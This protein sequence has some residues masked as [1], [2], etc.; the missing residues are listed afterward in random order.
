MVNYGAS[1]QLNDRMT[2]ILDNIL[3]AM[4]MTVS[5][6]Y[7]M[8]NAV[9]SSI[10][11]S[12][13][14][15]V[16]NTIAQAEIDFNSL[17]ET[18]NE[19]VK[20]PDPHGNE[21][22]SYTWSTDSFDVFT[23][24]GVDRYTSEIQSALN[25][26]NQLSSKQNEIAARAASSDV[27]SPSAV[28]DINNIGQRMNAI[29]EKIAQIESNPANPLDP[30]ASA[31]LEQMR[32]QLSQ[33]I[34]YQN[35]MNEAV[36]NLDVERANS[37]Y[38]QLNS[39]VN[40]TEQ[41]LRDNVTA[42]GQFNSSV[43]QGTA[44]AQGLSR[45]MSKIGSVFGVY[46]IVAGF[47]NVSSE[48][49]EFASNLTEVQNVV[50]VT[51]SSSAEKIDT[52]A[53]TT[54]DAFGLNELS[55]KQ[56]SGTMGA[57]L[58]SSGIAGDKITE[59]SMKVTELSGDMASFYNLDNE[60]AFNKIRSGISGETEPLKQLGINMSVAN[61][62][63]YALSQGISKS[64]DEMT[65]SEQTLLR[66]NYLLSVTADAQGDFARTQDS[67]ANQTKLLSENWKAFTG[68]IA[69]T[70]LPKLAQLATRLNTM[71][72]SS[73]FQTFADG[74]SRAINAVLT[75]ADGLL[76]VVQK[77]GSFF[78][79]NWS[80]ISPVIMGIVAALAAYAVYLGIVKTAEVVGTA[81][82]IAKCVAS[83]ALAAATRSEASANAMATAAQ[84]G[85]NTALLASPVTWIIIA[86]I[87][88]I[89]VIF[90]VIAAIKKATGIT[91]SALGMIV[92]AVYW[93]AALVVNIVVGLINGIIQY[94][95]AYF[96][97]PFIGIIEWILNVCNGGFDS[98]G[99]MAANLVGNIISWFL[100]LGQVVTRI[101]D[102]IFGTNWTAGLE[103]LKNTVTAWGKNDN[104]ISISRE[105]PTINYRMDMTDAYDRG[106]A[107]GDEWSQAI[108][109]KFGVLSENEDSANA[110][111]S[112][113]SNTAN[114]AADTSDIKNSV[115]S[116]SDSEL[117]YLRKIADR[118]A[119][120]KFTTAEIKLDVV[121]NATVNTD[122]DIDGYI[123]DLTNELAE[124]LVT[125]AEGL[126]E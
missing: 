23:D 105:A 18:M 89:A 97:E 36:E 100:S 61:L 16:R 76:T 8:Q 56:Y 114:T 95:W 110:L 6:V 96:V 116:S 80:L 117:E 113:E 58:K 38:R 59:M 118:E 101:I 60:T 50:D 70:A 75:A 27:F 67:Y 84:Y 106:A 52:W 83:Y 53:T 68:N 34:E 121:S 65:Q 43:R 73:E 40:S 77:I 41:N 24:T 7:D 90:I 103:S 91:T 48:A 25:M 42:Q 26:V 115:K 35:Q 87:A 57:M 71:F 112:I 88:L 66:Y 3:S 126:E 32:Q 14:D 30:S 63:A 81:V 9:S 123:D 125:T 98:L 37:L 31:E 45:V 11:L 102:A 20:A 99:D 107:K 49:V 47:K 46:K 62:E 5:T 1:I 122:L 13:F 69:S 94:L 82:T 120:N 17:K 55:A 22:Q 15:A 12:S 54:L 111:S 108:S 51:F 104:A 92:G 119:V 86:I 4:N 85:L 33:A 39:V 10:D 79:N 72:S 109:T 29:K 19:P 21:S 64:Y 2:P 124:V 44:D 93:L 74:M 28:A 78:V